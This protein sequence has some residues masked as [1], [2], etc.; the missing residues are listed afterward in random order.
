M[1]V[2]GS[3]ERWRIN[4][5]H[6]RSTIAATPQRFVRTPRFNIARASWNT[7]PERRRAVPVWERVELAQS[8]CNL[9]PGRFGGYKQMNLRRHTRIIN[10]ATR[11]DEAVTVRRN[12]RHH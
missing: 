11:R 2:V 8:V 10:K 5:E 4:L 9:V 12:A 1:A 6:N 7:V 3:G